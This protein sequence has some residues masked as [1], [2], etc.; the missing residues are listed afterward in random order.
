MKSAGKRKNTKISS[1]KFKCG[2]FLISIYSFV[3]MMTV[4]VFHGIG[5]GCSEQLFN[6]FNETEHRECAQAW[7]WHKECSMFP[8]RAWTTGI[9]AGIIVF[10]AVYYLAVYG[11]T[12]TQ[13]KKYNDVKYA[14]KR[15]KS[16]V[17]GGVIIGVFFGVFVVASL[18]SDPHLVYRPIDML[19][20][21]VLSGIAG[22]SVHLYNGNGMRNVRRQSFLDD[23]DIQ[24]QEFRF[25]HESSKETFHLSLIILVTILVSIPFALV[26]QFFAKVSFEIFYSDP[27]IKNTTKNI[28]YVLIIIVGFF[29]GIVLQELQNLV[30]VRHIIRKYDKHYRNHSKLNK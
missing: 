17:I 24:L 4:F 16:M 30:D 2:L 19:Y 15:R 25:D 21:L 26:F 27:F 1:M 10:F 28:G 3:S 12:T 14:K 18:L 9:I 11:A 6:M 29:V 13:L 20:S 8:L 7:A 22:V 23:K 5:R